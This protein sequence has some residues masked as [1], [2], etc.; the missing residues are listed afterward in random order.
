MRML[1]VIL[2]SKKCQRV[3]IATLSTKLHLAGP[4]AAP[5]ASLLATR[6]LR[7]APRAPHPV[8][9]GSVLFLRQVAFVIEIKENR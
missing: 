5:R 3:E 1:T 6:T 9:N 4:C 7:P 8:A 2:V